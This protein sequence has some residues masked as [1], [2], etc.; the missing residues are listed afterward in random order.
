MSNTHPE[1][2][3]PVTSELNTASVIARSLL[4]I[5]PKIVLK[6]RILGCLLRFKKEFK[7]KTTYRYIFSLHMFH[8]LHWSTV[9]IV[10]QMQ[11]FKKVAKHMNHYTFLSKCN[12]GNG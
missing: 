12:C 9:H 5:K 2:A 1:Q 4:F 8:D 7:K 10:V 11:D 6:K 3:W